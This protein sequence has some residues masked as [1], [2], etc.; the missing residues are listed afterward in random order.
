[1]MSRYSYYDYYDS[2]YLTVSERKEKAVKMAKRLAKKRSNLKPVLLSGHKIATTFWGKAWCDNIET[3]RDY[4]NRLPRG[5]S[6]LRSGAVVDLQIS[7]GS[8]QALVAGG[9]RNPYQVSV[10]IKPLALKKWNALKKKCVGK[11][12]SLINLAQGK[13]SLETLEEFC[14]REYGLFPSRPEISYSCSCPDWADMCKHIAAVLYGIGARLDQEPELFFVLRGIDPNELIGSEVVDALTG[15]VDSEVPED[16][17]SD[18]FGVE[19][20]T[21]PEAPASAPKKIKRRK[22]PAE[23]KHTKKSQVVKYYKDG[24]SSERISLLRTGGH[25][26]VAEFA[27]KLRVCPATI[28]AWESGIC[29]PNLSN[30]IRLEML[31]QQLEEEMTD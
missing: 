21:L 19:F 30:R 5:R 16:S 25:L 12:S 24:W 4:D 22:I 31:K 17:L 27:R 8:V 2:T 3:F 9:G 6:Y 23:K 1:M 10:K 11:I 14:K 20:D 15:G 29:G 18:I 28:A 26:S 13:L 7:T